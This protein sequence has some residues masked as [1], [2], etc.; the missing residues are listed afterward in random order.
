MSKRKISLKVL[1]LVAAFYFLSAS[2]VCAGDI[3]QADLDYDGKVFPSDAMILLNEWK[4]K[5][6]APNGPAPVPKTGNT[7]DDTTFEDGDLKKGV[8]WP[9]PRFTDNEDETVTDNL[10]G[11]MWTKDAYLTQDDWTGAIDEVELMNL[12]NMFGYRDWR[13]PNV[14]ELQSLIHYG[15]YNPALPNTTGTGKWSHDDPFINVFNFYWSSTTSAINTGHAWVVDMYDGY[16]YF[17]DK[18][19]NLL[20]WPVRGGH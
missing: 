5:D 13:L 2:T 3:C 9:N 20:V 14:R 8:A 15:V 19:N 10:T 1:V 7:I 12:I 18:S 16:V 17:Y 11:L 6:C 4:R